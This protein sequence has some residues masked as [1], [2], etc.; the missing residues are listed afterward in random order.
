MF[1]KRKKKQRKKVKSDSNS[2]NIKK[3][4]LFAF[5][6][7]K[8]SSSTTEFGMSSQKHKPEEENVIHKGELLANSI[9]NF[10]IKPPSPH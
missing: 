6:K 9:Q 10:T 2:L 4:A 8:K 7:N 5:A 3:H 1:L